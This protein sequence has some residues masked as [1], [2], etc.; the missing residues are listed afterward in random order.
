MFDK[1]RRNKLTLVQKM[2]AGFAAMAILSISAM[3]FAITGLY[4]L[5]KT[6]RDIAKHDL[7]LLTAAD[8]MRD[9]L[10]A[11]ERATS[12]FSILM[13]PEYIEL[14]RQRDRDFAAILDLVRHQR[15]SADV[16]EIETLHNRYVGQANVLFSGNV[17]IMPNVQKTAETLTSAINAFEISQQKMVNER[18]DSAD[19]RE[20][21][22]VGATLALSFGGFALAV[23][24]ATFVTINISNALNKLKKATHRIAEGDFDYDPQIPGGDEIGSLAQDFIKM[25][26]R[27]K[28]LE[29]QSL[30]ASPLTRLPGNIA[31][32]RILNRK[33]LS[34]APF[35]VCYADLDNFKAYN[36]HYGYIQASEVIRL[37]G[38][39][40]SETVSYLERA[41]D[42]VGHV[43]GDD[44]V[45]VVSQERVEE[46]C[47]SVINRFDRMIRDN[48]TPEDLAAGAIEG[49]DR[50]GVPRSFPIMTISIA[51]LLCGQGEYESAVE[52]ARDAAEIKDF[53]KGT[54]GSNYHIN[55]RKESR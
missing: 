11:Q 20:R 52:I 19:E 48:Y 27:L 21:S 54:P 55:R 5:H 28:E 32:E 46:I 25:A 36:D 12:K 33:L 40:I 7:V 26:G 53:V 9:T 50:Y 44:F 14:F 24:I 29:Q 8:S 18:L 15:Q 47:Q 41:D 43:G 1:P 13:T 37:T 22:T 3:L 6:A 42:F 4:S 30:D 34:S 31:I 51:V 39:I 49:I 23:I 35:A 17:G 38:Q 10:Q 2:I 16:A 45:M